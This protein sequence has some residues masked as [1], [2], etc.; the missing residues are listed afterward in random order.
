MNTKLSKKTKYC[1]KCKKEVRVVETG[2]FNVL[3]CGKC[4]TILS[5]DIGIDKS[6]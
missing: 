3:L 5:S 1:S 6:N 4:N 2:V